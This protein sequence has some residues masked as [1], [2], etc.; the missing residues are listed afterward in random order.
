MQNIE[1]EKIAKEAVLEELLK[2]YDIDTTPSELQIIC[3]A[4]TTDSLKCTIWGKPMKKLYAEITYDKLQEKIYVTIHKLLTIGS[5]P[6][7]CF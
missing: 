2:K 6:L 1:F 5:Y 7:D 3:Y 4:Q